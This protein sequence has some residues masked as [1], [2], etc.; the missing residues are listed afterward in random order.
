M[1]KLCMHAYPKCAQRRFRSDCANAQAD[2]NLRYAH[3]SGGTFSNV[4]THLLL[5]SVLARE[6]IPNCRWKPRIVGE[7]LKRF[8]IL[9][10]TQYHKVSQW[11]KNVHQLFLYYAASENGQF[12]LYE[13]RRP[14][15]ACASAPYDQGLL[16]S[17]TYSAISFESMSGQWRPR[18]ACAFAQADLSLSWPHML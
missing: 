17:S 4:V 1:K 10:L 7:S 8:D 6:I 15:S 16:S 12:A 13:L 14:R 5:L 11:S 18:P 3:M 9:S 2:L